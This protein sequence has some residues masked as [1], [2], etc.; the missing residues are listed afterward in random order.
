[1]V[2]HDLKSPLRSIDALVEWLREDYADS[3]DVE[4][5]ETLHLIRNNVAKM[6]ALI[7]GILEYSTIDKNNY[8]TYRVNLHTL[9][10]DVLNFVDIPKSIDVRV[11]NLLPSV[12]GDKYRLQQLFQNLIDNAITYNDKENGLIEIGCVDVGEYYEFY[13]RDNGKGIEKKFLNKIFKAFFKLGNKESSVG[14]GLSI[15][16]K[17]VELYEGK[18]WVLSK[19]EQGT[20]IYFTLKK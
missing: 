1:M 17:I 15:V 11:N 9:V 19:L 5:Q 3:L 4:G 6:E 10:E 14:I 8:K 16:K 18:I 20:T 7:T 13:I 2:S 12:N